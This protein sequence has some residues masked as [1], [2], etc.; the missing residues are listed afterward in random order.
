VKIPRII[1]LEDRNQVS[2]G[3][4]ENLHHR[5]KWRKGSKERD[6]GLSL[7]NIPGKRIVD[8]NLARVFQRGAEL[9]KK[10]KKC[11]DVEV[12]LPVRSAI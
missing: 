7:K 8:N 10:C 1:K 5:R 3:L 6:N 9:K 4:G 2:I 12:Q 11:G